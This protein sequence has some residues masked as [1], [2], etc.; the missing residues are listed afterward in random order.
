MGCKRTYTYRADDRGETPARTIG[1]SQASAE[2]LVALFSAM[3]VDSLK[4]EG[5]TRDRAWALESTARLRR[6]VDEVQEP[7]PGL[8][9]YVSRLREADNPDKGGH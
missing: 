9:H 5:R 7:D 2:R 6:A 4:I 3:G 8:L 1:G